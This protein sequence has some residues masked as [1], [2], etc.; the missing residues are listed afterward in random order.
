MAI[1]DYPSYEDY[2]KSQEWMLKRK[3]ALKAAD[4]R[5]ERCGAAINL[6]V[7]HTCYEPEE[8]SVLC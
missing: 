7:H 6:Q 5:C 4:F 8:L 3:L 1:H 2:L